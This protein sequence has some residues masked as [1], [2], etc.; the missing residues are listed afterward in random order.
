ML[1]SHVCL[2]HSIGRTSSSLRHSPVDELLRCLDG[3]TLAVH[4]VLRIDDQLPLTLSVGLAV[5]VHTSG[6]E[7]LLRTGKSLDGHLRWIGGLLWFH[8]QVSWL[9]VIVVGSCE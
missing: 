1:H 7:S 6:T 9:I 4:T 5:L 2:H 8:S 3:A